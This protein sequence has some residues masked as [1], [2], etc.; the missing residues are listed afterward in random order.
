MAKNDPKDRKN[1]HSIEKEQILVLIGWRNNN[2]F[3]EIIPK[4]KCFN[5]PNRDGLTLR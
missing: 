2:N 4:W 3:F 5:N 1:P